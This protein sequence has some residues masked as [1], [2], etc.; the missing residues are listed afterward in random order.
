MTSKSK[1]IKNPSTVGRKATQKS[2]KKVPK[3][4]VIVRE[5][6]NKSEAIMSS[7]TRDYIRSLANPFSGPLACV[8]SPYPNWTRKVRVFSRGNF[9]T[10]STNNIGLIWAD[11]VNSSQ[12]TYNCVLSTTA[13]STSTTFTGYNATGWQG[14]PSNADYTGVQLG[15]GSGIQTRVVSAGLR[16]RYAGTALNKGGRIIAFQDPTHTT[17][18]NR[19]ESTLLSEIQA[20][21]YAVRDDG[22]WTTILYSP[23]LDTDYQLNQWN[24]LDPTIAGVASDSGRF[25]MGFLIVSATASTPFYYEFF[26]VH[27]YQGSTVRGQELSHADPIGLSV[28]ATVSTAHLPTQ[29]S[30]AAIE[31][32]FVSTASKYLKEG[33]SYAVHNPGN[34]IAGVK[35]AKDVYNFSQGARSVPILTEALPFLLA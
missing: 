32:S 33:I 7:C 31:S 23:V 35:A 25:Y 19:A 30:N 3:Q 29:A 18:N 10:S 4:T 27:E 24:I 11:P 1:L 26:A 34:V 2:K 6:P 16:I 17:L 13:A 8:P 22:T 12:S 9:V 5:S 15:T 28:G 21:E 14:S 20:K